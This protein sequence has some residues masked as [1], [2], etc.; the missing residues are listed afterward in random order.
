MKKS[1]RKREFGAITPYTI[2]LYSIFEKNFL[3]KRKNII[4]S[5]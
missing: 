5:D 4:A 1:Y 2:F 3:K